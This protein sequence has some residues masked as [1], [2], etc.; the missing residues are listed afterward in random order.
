VKFLLDENLP[1]WL[2]PDL[3][4][5]DIDAV[6][7]REIGRVGMADDEVYALAKREKRHLISS[8]Y[9]DFRNP[10]LYPPTPLI[11]IVVVRLPKCSVRTAVEHVTR[12][13]ARVKQSDLAGCLIVLEST[14]LRRRKISQ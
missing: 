9:K 6:D 4:R 2:A 13:L 3:R 5:M 10:L 1:A 12:Y 11:G 8:N 7:V 14:R